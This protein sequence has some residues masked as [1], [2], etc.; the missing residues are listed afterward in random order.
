MCYVLHFNFKTLHFRTYILFVY[1]RIGMY[2]CTVRAVVCQLLLI[3]LEW[4]LP[5]GSFST[6]H[7][8]MS[9]SFTLD[10]LRTTL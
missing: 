2:M 4:Q 5:A 9:E 6:V 1:M 3:M 7:S 10:L 8:D